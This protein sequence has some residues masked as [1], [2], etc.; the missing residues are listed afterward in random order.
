MRYNRGMKYQ[1]KRRLIFSFLIFF[2]FITAEFSLNAQ[3][4]PLPPPPPPKDS[5]H[6]PLPPYLKRDFFPPE[7]DDSAFLLKGIRISPKHENVIVLKFLFNKV[8]DPLSISD[9]KI[10]INKKTI[11]TEEIVFSKDGRKIRIF[12]KEI[13]EPFSLN[14]SGLK[15]CNGE[16]MQTVLIEEMTYD[17]VYYFSKDNVWKKHNP[18][19][20]L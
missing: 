15:A 6:G 5:Y 19:S 9:L 13:D 18:K 12:L 17:S 4:F 16:C 14:I 7:D 10:Y 3:N 2:V 20:N 8:L 1:A 11:K